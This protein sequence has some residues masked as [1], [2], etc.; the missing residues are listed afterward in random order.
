MIPTTVAWKEASVASA[1][2]LAC[3]LPF[4]GRAF[5][6]DDP[7]F[8]WSAQQIRDHPLDPFGFEV[9]WYGWAMP[10]AEVTQN[11][12][13]ACYY[14][15]LSASVLG[16]SETALHVAFLLPA[17]AVVWGTYVLAR[18]LCGRPMIATLATVS[19]PVFLVSANTVMSDVMMLA[20]WLW[21]IIL[22]DRGLG[23]GRQW[24]LVVSAILIGFC[25][26]TK[27]FGLCLVPLLAA[28][29]LTRRMSAWRALV[30]LVIPISIMA[31]YEM[32]T[33][34]I[35][36]RGMLLDAIGYTS[37]SHVKQQAAATTRLLAGLAFTGGAAGSVLMLTPL[38][39]SRRQWPWALAAVVAAFLVLGGALF[40]TRIQLAVWCTVG[41]GVLVLAIDD[42]R[43]TRRHEAVLLLLWVA[44]TFVFATQI[45][46]LV[47]GRS[48]L[49]MVP[50]V[51][52]LVARYFDRAWPRLGGAQVRALAG[53]FAVAVTLAVAVTWAD[54]R[55]ANSTRQAA[56]LIV[57]K[58]I[59]RPGTLWLQDHWGFQYYGQQRGA[60][61]QDESRSLMLK[62]DIL[63]I[64]DNASNPIIMKEGD[65]SD[66]ERISVDVPAWIATMSPEVS[67]RFYGGRGLSLPF[68]FGRVKPE[69]YNIYRMERHIRYTPPD[70]PPEP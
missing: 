61:P 44:G 65:T 52:I 34:S 63:V 27:Y 47:N 69:Q 31:A 4:S 21:S 18:R 24:S 60:L 45:N 68:A 35:Y 12:P 40:A 23:R 8:L 42:L 16:W 50:A 33:A 49:P 38:L 1:L 64:S 17:L 57:D 41:L 66:I 48:V 46:W 59:D 54:Y 6:I 22:W 26:L 15:A 55:L 56:D 7:L 14:I 9:N 67:A 30:Y 51:A 37:A 32:V 19:S 5:H 13:I 58:Y 36:G 62:G 28:Y 11:P 2:L 25:G 39:I 20:V 43:A 29:T 53:G 70:G 3:L 10:M